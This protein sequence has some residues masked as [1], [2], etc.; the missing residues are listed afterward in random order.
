M[1][2]LVLLLGF[3]QRYPEIEVVGTASRGEEALERVPELKPR[4]VLVD[5]NL[6]GLSGLEV[7]RCLRREGPQVGLIALTV[8]D[9]DSY[10]QP[11]LNSGADAFVSKAE[12]IR[13]L[14]PAIR[15]VARQYRGAG[16]EPEI[17]YGRQ[18]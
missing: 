12:L 11:A 9:A 15:Q 18:R 8:L 10:R 13:D 6:P 1:T 3:T 5:L 2:D 16:G 14:L 17:L 4:I 7:L